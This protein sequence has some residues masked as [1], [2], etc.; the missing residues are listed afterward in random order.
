VRDHRATTML[1]FKAWREGKTRFLLSAATI[2][3]LC[4]VVVLFNVQMQK[5]PGP[6]P[7]GF[8]AATYSEHI[9]HFIYSGTAKGL[10]TM[11]MLLIGLGGLLREGRR[12][13]A[14]FTL[15]LPATR[16]EMIVAQI[17]VGILEVVAI[18]GLPLLLIPTLSPFVDQFY[19]A[20]ESFHFALLWLGGGLMVFG[21]AFLCSVL[22]AGEYTA[23]VAAFLGVFA[24]PLVAQ[25]RAL[26][27]YRVNFLMTMGEFGTMHWNSRHTLLLPSPMPWIR[28]L[29][30]FGISMGL[31]WAALMVTRRQDF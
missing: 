23:L 10:F 16:T 8:R 31:L 12:G 30:F 1:L 24:V 4:T 15:A 29:V 17:A 3:M 6:I 20:S 2:A 7:H 25:V 5:N 21:L 9:Y 28:L 19:P 27:P 14:P 13:T 18:A 11:L 26:E 22:F